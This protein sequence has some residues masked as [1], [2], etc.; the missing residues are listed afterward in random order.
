M[1]V[2]LHGVAKSFVSCLIKHNIRLVC[3][4][5]DETITMDAQ[6]T[7]SPMFIQLVKL[8]PEAGIFVVVT[9]LNTRFDIASFLA[10][11]GIYIKVFAR[12]DL[13]DLFIGKQWH[14]QEA[15]SYVNSF[16]V[17]PILWHQIL[18]IDDLPN[19]VYWF[20]RVG[21]TALEVQDRNGLKSSDLLRMMAQEDSY[22]TNSERE[23]GPLL[24]SLS[25]HFLQS[26]NLE[27][28]IQKEC[29]RYGYSFCRVYYKDTLLGIMTQYDMAIC[30]AAY[31]AP[32]REQFKM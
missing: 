32:K 15:L 7:L 9:T 28:Q 10:R 21:G 18:L 24:P 19:N 22:F 1:N 27:Y 13:Q 17:T 2:M 11:H 16:L 20:R 26:T 12:A 25:N 6:R 29:D 8:L 31:P 5:F 14:I 4:D 3:F 23:K 30:R